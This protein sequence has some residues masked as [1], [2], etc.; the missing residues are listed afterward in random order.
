M[1]EETSKQAFKK[2]NEEGL[3]GNMQ[4]QVLQ[5]IKAL[6]DCTDKEIST[7]TRIPINCVTPRR[8][9]LYGLNLITQKNTRN[10]SVTGRQAKTWTINPLPTIHK[11]NKPK[12]QKCPWCN[13]KGHLGP[14][15]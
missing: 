1:V 12:R 10:C 5:A 7:H 13:G 4:Q 15:K 9:E 3:L 8:N 11:P 6:E 2:I 14:K